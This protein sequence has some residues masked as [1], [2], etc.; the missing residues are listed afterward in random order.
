MLHAIDHSLYGGRH[1]SDDYYHRAFH[2]R[3]IINHTVTASV[4]P[5]L[6][7]VKK[8]AFFPSCHYTRNRVCV[9]KGS[10]V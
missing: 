8:V 1:F 7:N 5:I 2:T 4:K 6:Y 10:V 3:T 9:N